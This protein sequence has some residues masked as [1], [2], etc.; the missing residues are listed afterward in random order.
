M[1]VGLNYKHVPILMDE[2]G[3]ETLPGIRWGSL[4]SYCCL[5][6]LEEDQ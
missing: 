4:M 2:L 6:I 5:E 1:Y 3:K